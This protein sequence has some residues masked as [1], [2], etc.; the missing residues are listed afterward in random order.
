VLFR[1]GVP[2]RIELGP[3]DVGKGVMVMVRRDTGAKVTAKLDEA[4]ESLKNLLED[5]HETMFSKYVTPFY[6]SFILRSSSL[7]N[8][9]CS[10]SKTYHC[11]LF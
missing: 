8:V 9:I 7:L 11:L 3:R 4:V 1:Q 10:I 5:I 2:V 6:R